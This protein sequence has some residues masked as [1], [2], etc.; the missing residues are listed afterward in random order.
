MVVG[1]G[2]Q[3]AFLRVNF[4]VEIL[5]TTLLLNHCTSS[6]ILRS[7]IIISL[8]VFGSVYLTFSALQP[9][10]LPSIMTV[11]VFIVFLASVLV[12]LSMLN[13]LEKSILHS[14]DF[15]FSAGI[16]FHFGL[17]S[18]LLFTGQDI[19]DVDYHRSDGFSVLYVAIFII[20]FLFFATGVIMEKPWNKNGTTRN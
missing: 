19:T 5:F 15:W 6:R 1:S 9:T 12:L 8:I 10:G 18:L 14:P 3:D 16:F 2:L 11:G 4:F 17:L 20:Q 13:D 7:S